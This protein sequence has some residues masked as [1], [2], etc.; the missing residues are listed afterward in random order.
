MNQIKI[1]KHCYPH[2]IA[3]KPEGQ[4]ASV[5]FLACFLGG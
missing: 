2:F 1:G 3:E 4:R 5:T